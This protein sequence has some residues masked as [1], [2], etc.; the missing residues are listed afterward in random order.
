MSVAASD[1]SSIESSRYKTEFGIW[2][3]LATEVLFFNALFLAFAINKTRHP[4]AFLIAEKHTDLFYGTLN[5]AVLL[6]SSATVALAV[7][8]ADAGRRRLAVR[9]LAAT[10]GLALCF[11]AVKGLEYHSDVVKG[12]TPGAGFRLTPP[13]TA[14]FWTLYW[15]M[16]GVHAVHVTVG[17]LVLGFLA[18]SARAGR[19]ELRSGAIE[20]AALYWHFVDIVWIFLYPLLYLGGRAT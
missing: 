15:V 9:L 20:A 8:A 18:W 7:K 10:I 12:L 3:F 11:L 1:P 14:L 17:I 13:D 6:T 2:I 16:T 5:T 19:I 4:V